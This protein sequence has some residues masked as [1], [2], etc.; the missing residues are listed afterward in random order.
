[1]KNAWNERLAGK[2]ENL[3]II[4]QNQNAIREQLNMSIDYDESMPSK[5][6]DLKNYPELSIN[7]YG[8]TPDTKESKCN[9][10]LFFRF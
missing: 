7:K 2:D 1:M 5:I 6:V 9:H 8:F 10:L 4:Q 3:K